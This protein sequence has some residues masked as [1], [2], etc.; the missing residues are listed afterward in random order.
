MS[1]DLV[2]QLDS[3]MIDSD[4]IYAL[5]KYTTTKGMPSIKRSDH[6]T[7]I[8]NLSVNWKEEK[9]PHV[10]I[11]KLR[12]EVGLGKFKTKTVTVPALMECFRADLRI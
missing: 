9:A 1:H 5:T 8:A 4:Q 2:K 6:Y 3:A 7:L 10:E 11:F 12:D